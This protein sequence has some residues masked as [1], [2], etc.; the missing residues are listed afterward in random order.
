MAAP[1]QERLC[2]ILATHVNDMLEEKR[3]LLSTIAQLQKDIDEWNRMLADD[4]MLPLLCPELR[5][6]VGELQ[7]QLNDMKAAAEELP[8][9]PDLR[10][11][12]ALR[13]MAEDST[14]E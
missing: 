10:N 1:W 5:A 2:E 4:P 9:V 7:L 12:E 13:G 3:A 6:S 14:R 8:I 11:S